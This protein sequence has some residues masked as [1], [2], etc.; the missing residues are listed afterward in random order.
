MTWRIL[1]FALLTSL[2]PGGTAWAFGVDFN[3]GHPNPRGAA[4]EAD[5]MVQSERLEQPLRSGLFLAWQSEMEDATGQLPKVGGHW[6]LQILEGAAGN[7]KRPIFTF[8]FG[9]VFENAVLPVGQKALVRELERWS[10]PFW[11][12]NSARM[13][14][15]I[16]HNI[17]Q[18]PHRPN[19]FLANAGAQGGL[20][21]TPWPHT[22]YHVVDWEL[23]TWYRIRLARDAQPHATTA[24]VLATRPTGEHYFLPKPQ[25][26]TAYAWRVTL[27]PEI[28]RPDGSFAPKGA[29]IQLVPF[30]LDS[31]YDRMHTFNCWGEALGGTPRYPLRWYQV[32]PRVTMLDGTV[33]GVGQAQAGFWGFDQPDNDA[34]PMGDS[35]VTHAFYI[36]YNGR[37]TVA[38]RTFSL[39]RRG[40]RDQGVLWDDSAAAQVSIQPRPTYIEWDEKV[41]AAYLNSIPGVRYSTDE[42]AYAGKTL[43]VNRRLVLPDRLLWIEYARLLGPGRQGLVMKTHASDDGWLRQ[44][45]GR[46]CILPGVNEGMPF[47]LEVEAYQ[48]STSNTV[49]WID[50]LVSFAPGSGT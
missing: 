33:Q 46:F 38:G 21:S 22:L 48:P 43:Y 37:P 32:Q 50:L 27:T 36:G 6:G 29:P 44:E 15:E 28:Q 34:G 14:A 7:G 11:I 39:M 9:W 5:V 40:M 3:V 30:F 19:L 41:L 8:N 13:K 4:F 24:W 2:A 1:A 26:V 47:H 20:A 35:R 45:P 17:A 31:R 42:V 25:Q 49:G 16:E 18:D 10:H 12:D 23:D